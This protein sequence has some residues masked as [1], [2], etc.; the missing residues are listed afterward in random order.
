MCFEHF[1][2]ACLAA[3]FI[4]HNKC[5]C[6][7]SLKAPWLSESF[8]QVLF[9]DVSVFKSRTSLYQPWLKKEIIH[10]YG[11]HM[12][13]DNAVIAF[14][15]FSQD[16]FWCFADPGKSCTLHTAEG[17]GLADTEA[18]TQIPLSHLLAL[19]CSRVLSYVGQ[20]LCLQIKLCSSK[21]EGSTC[22]P[23]RAVGIKRNHGW[24]A[25]ECHSAPS[26][27]HLLKKESCYHGCLM[28]LT[29]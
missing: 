16:P 1:F 26:H 24:E 18:H 4:H 9:L 19:V 8:L 5:L 13:Y 20:Y 14:I 21:R 22:L 23:H 7:I 11:I 17:Q 27:E 12:V 6:D 3:S 25:Y 15:I 29:T 2:F 28:S 10:F